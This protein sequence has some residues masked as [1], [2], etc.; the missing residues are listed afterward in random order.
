MMLT[1]LLGFI[2]SPI[3]TAVVLFLI[4]MVF[5]GLI[6]FARLVVRFLGGEI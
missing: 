3:G 1:L 4:A 2:A 6:E 5:V